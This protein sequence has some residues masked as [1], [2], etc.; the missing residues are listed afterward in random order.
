M[1][2][3]NPLALVAGLAIVLGAGSLLVLAWVA[4]TTDWFSP[5]GGRSTPTIE[6]SMTDDLR[7]DPSALT[8]RSGQTIRFAITN[9]TAIEHEFVVGDEVLQEVHAEVMVG[10]MM[11][12]DGHSV[13][14][15]SGQTRELI[16]T[17][18]APGTLLIGCHVAGHYEA[19]MHA[20]INVTP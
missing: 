6:V 8:V 5:G 3:R 1:R 14:V 18:G 13:A 16:F 20:S 11:H 15:P 19:G 12:D 17:F 9:P 2:L 4:V 7:Y 10:G